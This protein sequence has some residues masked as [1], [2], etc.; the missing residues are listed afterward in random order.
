MGK[1]KVGI[2]RAFFYYIY[3]PAWRTY[4]ESLGCEV[5]TSPPTTKEII[6]LGVKDALAEA[7][8]PVKIFFGHVQ[9]IKDKVDYLF[10]PRVMSMNGKTI[11][12]PKFLGLPDMIRSA[13]PNL[14]KLIDVTIDLR[15]DP[16]TLHRAAINVAKDMGYTAWEGLRALHKA[17]RIHRHYMALLYK[18]VFPNKAIQYLFSDN[19]DQNELIDYHI[20]KRRGVK[21]TPLR[22][23]ILGYPYTVHDSFV[24]VNLFGKLR[25]M[26]VEVVTMEMMNPQIL[27]KQRN[28]TVKRIF[29]TFSEMVSRTAYHFFEN[30]QD[31]DGI[32]HVTAFGCGPDFMVDK[33]ME[34]EA[35]NKN[36]QV[37][38]MSLSI[39]E[40]TGEAG[41]MTRIEAFCE[42]VRRRKEAVG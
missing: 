34:I 23:A 26:E 22:L 10:I 11:Y 21:Q 3:Y 15:K 20:N 18:G 41:I 17:A 8:V 38:F 13:I 19:P 12:C 1:I 4:F 16:L 28:K 5:I 24:N 36:S 27:K 40:H 6:D 25:D 37:P 31:I 39:D 32:L 7:C 33:L 29:W 30:N 35:K 9:K 42:L 14:S 2:P